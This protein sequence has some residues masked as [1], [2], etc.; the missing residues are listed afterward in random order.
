MEVQVHITNFIN[1]KFKS[2]GIIKL[3][4]LIIIFLLSLLFLLEYIAPMYIFLES[5]MFIYFSHSYYSLIL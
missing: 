1:K 5:H 4:S 2:Q 3:I